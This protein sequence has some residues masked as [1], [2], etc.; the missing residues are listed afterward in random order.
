MVTLAGN[1]PVSFR[2]NC[3]RERST[4]EASLVS[5]HISRAHLLCYTL[6]YRSPST[7]NG[8]CVHPS[9]VS[10]SVIPRTVAHQAP[11][12]MGFPR[13]GY[14]SGLPFPSPGDLPNPGIEPVSPAWQVL[15][16]LYTNWVTWEASSDRGYIPINP[17][18]VE[19]TLH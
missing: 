18:Y 8:G 4:R 7:S 14:W 17:S 11:L 9:V 3:W 19:N 12:S 5:F 6:T 10:D 2:K 16:I 15:Q 1:S 13:Q